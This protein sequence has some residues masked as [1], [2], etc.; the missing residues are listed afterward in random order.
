VAVSL[1]PISLRASLRAVRL[2]FQSA[3][4]ERRGL[5]TVGH[6]ANVMR[7]T[8][9]L[10]LEAGRRAA[11]EFPQIKYEEVLIDTLCGRLV[12]DPSRYEVIAL[13]NLF[14]DIVSDIGAALVG[15]TGMA[16]GANVGPD[17]AIFEAVHGTADRLAGRD[18]ANPVGLLSAGVSLLRR[19]G[20][21]G[22][23]AALDDALK[24][25]IHDPA[26]ATYDQKP[27]GRPV[28]TT[29]FGRLVASRIG[30]TKIA[31]GPR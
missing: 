30:A 24:N 6:K 9:G 29:E 5:V 23:A 13:P 3:A 4:D 22:A 25:V 14:G 27:S 7:A 10:F 8:D 2:A 11:R 18:M 26:L 20:E 12:A 31:V 28:G 19:L 21:G 16:P 17:C 15:G 1:R